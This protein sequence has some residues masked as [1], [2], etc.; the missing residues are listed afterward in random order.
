[1]LPPTTGTFASAATLA[2]AASTMSS[3]MMTATFDE[4]RACASV[5]A[6]AG[7]VLSSLTTMLTSC[8]FR[9]PA[10]FTDLAQPSI[11][12]R[13]ATKTAPKGPVQLQITPTSIFEPFGAG[14]D[15]FGPDFVLPPLEE[16]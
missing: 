2:H 10:A 11:T 5:R 1:M 7:L 9:P 12:D 6:V 8:P 14:A 16:H 15:C 4:M 3:S 13:A